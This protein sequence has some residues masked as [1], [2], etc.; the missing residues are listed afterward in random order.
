MGSES[1]SVMD[2]WQ[3]LGAKISAWWASLDLLAI[4]G[5][6]A[7]IILVVVAARVLC[8]IIKRI[9]ARLVGRGKS[10]KDPRKVKTLQTLFTSVA[11]YTVWFFAIATILGILGLGA[12]LSSL[13]AT[14]GIG[15]LALG[16]G[17]Q[18]LLKDVITGFFMLFDDQ[19]AVGDMIT[20]DD[21]TGTV[22]SLSLRTTTL[23]LFS[24][25]MVIIPNGRIGKVSN[26]SRGTSLAIVDCQVVNPAEVERALVVME[27]VA[28]AFDGHEA[29]LEP[30]VVLGVTLLSDVQVQLRMVARTKALEHWSVE[31]AIRLKLI[32]EMEKAHIEISMRRMMLVGM[33][34]KA[35]NAA[36]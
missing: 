20:I 8:G 30:P 13:L 6:I 34:G 35:D 29:L 1:A 9:V 18:S 3:E 2:V 23:R 19:F 26:Q 16:L 15:G 4:A 17:A 22:E 21:T 24:G 7:C 10:A 31:R 28:R 5:D 14:A 12:T 25:E 27:Q 32:E 33:A 11:R 36:L